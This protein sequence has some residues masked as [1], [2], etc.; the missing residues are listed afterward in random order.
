MRNAEFRNGSGKPVVALD[1]DGTL[2]DYHSWFL[3]FAQM[4]FGR[5]MPNPNEINPGLPL[6]KFMRVKLHEYRECKLAY[7]QGGMKR[8]MEAYPGAAALSAAIRDAGAELWLCT[9]RPYLRLDNIDPDTR[10]WL[11]RN[12]VEYDAIL[13]DGLDKPKYQEL[14]DQVELTRIVAVVDDLP[15]QIRNA[16]DAGIANRYLRDQPYNRSEEQMLNFPAARRVH[17]CVEIQEFVVRDIEN[18]NGAHSG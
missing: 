18:W 13:F 12:K 2:G 6:W 4:Y 8:G 15:E 9:T 11:R 7:R 17:S 5:H 16:H 3:N 1:I 14:V 10:E